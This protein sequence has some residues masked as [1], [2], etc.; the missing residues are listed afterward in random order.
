MYIKKN[1]LD[2]L[3][4]NFYLEM[5]GLHY[6]FSGF[7][8]FNKNFLASLDYLYSGKFNSPHLPILF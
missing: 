5:Y 6:F 1:M 3:C 8:I 7:A 2:F 4:F